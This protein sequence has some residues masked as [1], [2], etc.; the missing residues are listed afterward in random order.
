[1]EGVFLP[2]EAGICRVGNLL[3]DSHHHPLPVLLILELSSGKRELIWHYPAV[4]LVQN[5]SSMDR[6]CASSCC[7]PIVL[8]EADVCCYSFLI[9]P[10]SSC[11]CRREA[12][13]GLLLLLAQMMAL[14]ISSYSFFP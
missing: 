11:L 1:M 13:Y 12:Q 7:K 6:S 3:P 8:C 4:K 9:S 2:C 10:L 5:S 14:W